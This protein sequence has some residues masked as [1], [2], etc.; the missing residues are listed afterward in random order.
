MNIFEW[1][2]EKN[3]SITESNILFPPMESQEAIDFLR[4]YLLGDNWQVLNLLPLSHINTEIVFAILQKYSKQYKK[5]KKRW[6]KQKI[7]KRI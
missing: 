2:E 1:L 7:K 4:H 3:T 5:D 6:E